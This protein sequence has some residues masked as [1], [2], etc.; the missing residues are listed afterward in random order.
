MDSLIRTRYSRP[1]RKNPWDDKGPGKNTLVTKRIGDILL[2]GIARCNLHLD[3]FVKK[4]GRKEAIKRLADAQ[5]LTEEW[6]EHLAQ[7]PPGH[8][9]MIT[10]SDGLSGVCS[11]SIVR[12]LIQHFEKIDENWKV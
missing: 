12:G 10:S 9:M 3:T 8:L 1:E 11:V 6:A 5:K 7:D 2:F 4:E